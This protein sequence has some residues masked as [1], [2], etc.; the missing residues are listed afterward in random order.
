MPVD[1]EPGRFNVQLLGNVIADFSQVAAALPAGAAIRLVAVFNAWQV[2][3][4]RLAA[5]TGAFGFGH[6]GAGLRVAKR[7]DLSLDGRQVGV[8][9]FFEHVPLQ[10]RQGLALGAEADAFVIRQFMRQ[11]FDLEVFAGNLGGR[12]LLSLFEQ[13]LNQ[14]C[15]LTFY[16]RIKVQ[17]VKVSKGFHGRY[18]TMKNPLKLCYY[19]VLW[20][21]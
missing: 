11:R 10:C 9:G 8:P 20:G 1:K 18:F 14:C 21:F 17:L 5:S 16:G 6:R 13:C 19:S 2:T 15:Y 12:C 7:F 4:Q 3:R